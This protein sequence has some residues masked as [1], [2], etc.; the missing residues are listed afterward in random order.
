VGAPALIA[1]CG[2]SVV[3][4]V[5]AA[6]RPDA[7]RLGGSPV[8][9]IEA[10]RDHPASAAILTR[11]ADAALRAPLH[12]SGFEVVE[13]PAG[14]TFV[15]ELEIFGDGQRR[16]ALASFGDPFTPQDVATWMAPA[17]SR[18]RVAVLGAQW[19]GDFPAETLRALAASGR[20]L[21]LDG[22]GPARPER[23]GPLRLEG[24]LDPAWI[25][26]VQVVK[27]SDEEA[28][29]LFGDQIGGVPVVVIS[30][31]H[32]GAT[33]HTGG[34][35]VAVAAEPVLGLADT[36]GS[37]DMFLALLGLGLDAGLD[38]VAAARQA[39]VGVSDR[40]RRRLEAGA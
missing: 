29:A 10:L 13:G 22:Q 31:G 34:R 36:V 8:F 35:S 1:I 39:C 28:A 11:G 26:G 32:L 17:L 24:P 4:R 40:L 37:G 9:A 15:S 19:R 5:R 3:D 6:G 27:C 12:A 14:R 25:P 20:T 30:H 38:P 16:H 2:Q 23:L 21:L 7:V 18:A 33:V